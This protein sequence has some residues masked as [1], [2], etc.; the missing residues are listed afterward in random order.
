MFKLN[1][2]EDSPEKAVIHSRPYLN[3]SYPEH[4]PLAPAQNLRHTE[5][6]PAVQ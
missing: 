1:N 4:D 5:H 6:V 3:A 2:E